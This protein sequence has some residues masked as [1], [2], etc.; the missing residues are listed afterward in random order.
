LKLKGPLIEGTFID[1]PNRFLTNIRIGESIV[2]SHLPDPGRLK[3]LLYPGATV[4]LLEA[5]D[6]SSRR[7]NYTTVLV[8][9]GEIIVSLDSTLPNRL[10]KGLLINQE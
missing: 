3:E 6:S 9:A 1:R 10:V 4:Y 8:K 2:A 7:T 5:D